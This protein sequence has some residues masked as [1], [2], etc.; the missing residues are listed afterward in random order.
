MGGDYRRDGCQHHTEGSWGYGD[1]PEGNKDAL[2][3]SECIGSE[4]P[5]TITCI[6]EKALT[7]AGKWDGV[8]L[9]AQRCT[10]PG[11]IK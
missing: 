9:G 6:L 1:D 3:N 2:K 11:K 5:D 8:R 4:A 7:A 10:K